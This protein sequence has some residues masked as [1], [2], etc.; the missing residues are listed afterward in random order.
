LKL[1]GLSCGTCV[2]ADWKLFN[3]YHEN[4]EVVFS[5]AHVRESFKEIRLPIMGEHQ[6]LNATAV[7]AVACKLGLPEDKIRKS[8]LSFRGVHRQLERKGGS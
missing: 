2:E 4:L 7:W 5:T 8:F 1:T 3:V 6:A